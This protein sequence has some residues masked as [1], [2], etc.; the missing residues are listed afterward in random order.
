[1]QSLNIYEKMTC[2]KHCSTNTTFDDCRCS[3]AALDETGVALK[4]LIAAKIQSLKGNPD[5]S[6][7]SDS[8]AVQ[9]VFQ[10]MAEF[11]STSGHSMV[12]MSSNR[13]ASSSS[14]PPVWDNG[15]NAWRVFPAEMNIDPAHEELMELTFV[16][17]MCRMGQTGQMFSPFGAANDPL[18]WP[19]HVIHEKN[20]AYMRMAKGLNSSWSDSTVMRDTH[21]TGWAFDEPLAPFTG[22]GQGPGG[23]PFPRVEPPKAHRYYTNA[24]LVEVYSPDAPH[25]PFI[26]DD[27]GFAHCSGE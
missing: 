21:L 4:E 20:W 23:V 25:L 22:F 12:S 11:L 15:T 16:N 2:P 18:F 27:F 14:S 19:I 6:S 9:Q 3:C 1:V 8:E 26:W 10:D 24:E 7:P 13:D 17:V 5:L